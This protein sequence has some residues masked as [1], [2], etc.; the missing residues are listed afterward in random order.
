M[1]KS[2]NTDDIATFTFLTITLTPIAFIPVVP[3]RAFSM[4]TT[5]NY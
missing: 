1:T 3:L 2:V 5:K 4:H